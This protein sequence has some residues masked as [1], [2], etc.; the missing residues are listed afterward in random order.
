MKKLLAIWMVILV[1]AL[2]ASTAFAIGYCKDIAPINPPDK[3]FEDEWI[4][5][6]GEEIEID[7][8][9]NDPPETLLTAGVFIPPYDLPIEITA[10]QVYD[11]VN[12]PPGPWDPAATF[13]CWTLCAGP[14][15]LPVLVTVA[16]PLGAVP[17]EDGD[18]IICRIRIRFHEEGDYTIMVSTVL[19]VDTVMGFETSTVYDPQII[20]NT[21]TVRQI[22]EDS[23]ADG[24]PDDLDNCPAIPNGPELGICSDGSLIGTSCITHEDCGLGGLCESGICED[25]KVRGTSCTS[26][27]DCGTNGNCYLDQEE[28][29]CSCVSSFDCDLDVDGGDAAR[30]KMYFGNGPYKNPCDMYPCDGDFDCDTDVDGSDAATFKQGFGRGALCSSDYSASCYM[31]CFTCVDGV[32]A[33]TCTYE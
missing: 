8:Y 17:D 29:A 21:I 5:I 11:G 28:Y 25:G 26:D 7:I 1:L 14:P 10:V 33:Y 20:P 12:G 2:S 15:P 32:Y 9:L 3:T 18:M 31:P 24:I 30:F 22:I 13:N 19:G 16:N 4:G 6:V 27:E 23:D